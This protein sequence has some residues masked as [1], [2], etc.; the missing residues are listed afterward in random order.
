MNVN[1]SP[2]L[3]RTPR[4][5]IEAIEDVGLS[6]SESKRTLLSMVWRKGR[7]VGENSYFYSEIRI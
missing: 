4:L 5:R 3:G 1:R 2:I 6:P 7:G